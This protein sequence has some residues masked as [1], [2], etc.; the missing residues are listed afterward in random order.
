LAR[1]SA[2]EAAIAEQNAVIETATKTLAMEN[3]KPSSG[4]DLLAIESL[5]AELTCEDDEVRTYARGRV[6]MV[7]RR[8]I[9]RIAITP[10]G[11]FKIEPDA[12]SSWHFDHDG[13]MI[14]GAYVPS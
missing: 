4:D 12:F 9:G 11:T 13:R 1:V 8:L 14:E 2:L 6:N 3:S 10:V 7:L 5:R